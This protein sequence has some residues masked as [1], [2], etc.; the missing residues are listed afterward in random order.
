[1]RKTTIREVK[2]L[3]LLK[4]ENIVLLKDAFKRKGRLYLVFE[5]MHKNLL[6]VLEANQNGLPPETVKSYIY[7]L[8]RAIEWCHRHEVVHRGKSVSLPSLSISIMV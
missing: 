7:Q 4:Q 1:V 6:E 2:L 5:Y 8:L 3:N